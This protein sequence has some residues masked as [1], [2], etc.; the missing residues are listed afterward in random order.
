MFF[1][2]RKQVYSLCLLGNFVLF[3]LTLS[4]SVSVLFFLD[5]EQ[6][7]FKVDPIGSRESL[8]RFVFL[9]SYLIAV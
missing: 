9:K 1:I 6:D 8:S 2:F 7:K 5:C 3:L 4:L